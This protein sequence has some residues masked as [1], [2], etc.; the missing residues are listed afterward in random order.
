LLILQRDILHPACALYGLQHP[1]FVLQRN[2]LRS[3][4]ES[5]VVKYWSP[6]HPVLN[7]H[8]I[9]ALNGLQHLV[10][11]LQRDIL[12]PVSALNGLR[13]PELVLLRDIPHFGVEYYAKLLQPLADFVVSANFFS[14]GNE[15][16]HLNRV[17]FAYAPDFPENL[18][19]VEN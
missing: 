12:H 18:Q 17:F 14:F 13:H 2:I 19:C 5:C 15:K 16:L 7:F 6:V 8:P 9:S 11:V 1:V 3:A 4:D 10:P